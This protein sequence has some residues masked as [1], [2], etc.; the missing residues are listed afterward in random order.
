MYWDDVT[1]FYRKKPARFKAV[2]YVDGEELP[3][4][5]NIGDVTDATLQDGDWVVLDIEADR[6][7]ILKDDI[8]SLVFEK[9]IHD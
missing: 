6:T 4:V 8:F 1:D 9:D 7:F 5:R 2:Q 3:P